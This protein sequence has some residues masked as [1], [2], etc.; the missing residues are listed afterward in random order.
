MD[1]VKKVQEA[2]AKN[3]SFEKS[4]DDLTDILDEAA[5]EISTLKAAVEKY[6]KHTGFCHMNKFETGVHKYCTCGFEQALK[7]GK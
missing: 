4:I 1:I 2:A 3:Q 7:G 5:T 6:G